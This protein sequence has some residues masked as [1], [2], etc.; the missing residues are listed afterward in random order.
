MNTW[1]SAPTLFKTN[2]WLFSSAWKRKKGIEDWAK[3]HVN[4]HDNFRLPRY[5]VRT[6]VFGKKSRTFQG[7]ISFFQGLLSQNNMKC[8]GPLKWVGGGGLA[9]CNTFLHYGTVHRVHQITKNELCRKHRHHK[10]T[11]I[12]MITKKIFVYCCAFNHSFAQNI[13]F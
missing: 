8:K 7:L 13:F 1:R 2:L 9:Y 10:K 11:I 4:V 5:M 3:L 6:R 12:F